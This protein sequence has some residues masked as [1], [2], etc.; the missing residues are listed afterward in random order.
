MPQ[1][2]Y[3][4]IALILATATGGCMSVGASFG[5]PYAPMPRREAGRLDASGAAMTPPTGLLALCETGALACGR[6]QTANIMAP[7]SQDGATGAAE[8]RRLENRASGSDLFRAI[9]M[10]KANAG[11]APEPA[12]LGRAD[13]DQAL[14]R[15][16]TK[17]NL[18]VNWAIA[19]DT[20]YHVYGE[21]ERWAL[22]LSAPARGRPRG[23]CEDYVLEKRARLIAQGV[24]ADSLS[25]VVALSP[26]VGRHAVLVVRTSRGDFALDNLSDTPMDVDRLPYV[27]VSLQSGDELLS[28]SGVRSTGAIGRELRGRLRA[29]A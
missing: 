27:W 5:S 13:F 14:W 10:A 1:M 15:M 23:D 8:A 19:P 24:R 29:G 4:F 16:M 28:W 17:V 2:R 9:L 18:D 12:R 25:I 22:P 11:G 6:G 3:V 20:D 7:T 26:T 21:E